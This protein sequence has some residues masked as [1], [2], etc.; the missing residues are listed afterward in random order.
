MLLFYK[1]SSDTAQTVFYVLH[2]IHVILSALVTASIYK[3]YTNKVNPII[4]ILIGYIGSI[5][6]ISFIVSPTED[7]E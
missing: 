6:Y 2:P 4:L 7:R 1:I 3:K 5:C